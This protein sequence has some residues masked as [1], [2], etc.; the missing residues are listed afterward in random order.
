MSL[1][2]K[3][4]KINS[5]SD[6]NNA[7]L[8]IFNFQYENTPIYRKYVDI[9]KI[10]IEKIKHYKEIP[11]L[12]IQFFKSNQVL[13][14]N[15]FVE[16]TFKSSGTTKNN[17]SHHHIHNLELYTNSFTKTFEKFYGNID[18]WT[19]LALLPSY[20]EQGDSSL[21]Y[22]VNHLIKKS[23]INSSFIELDFNKLKKLSIELKEQKV[24]LIGVSYAL[25]EIAEQGNLNLNNWTIMETGGMKGRRKEIVREE[26][27][28]E[29]VNAF[30]V[31]FIHSEYGM[32]E[33]LTQAYSKGK[34]VFSTPNWMKILIR[35]FEDPFSY[36]MPLNSGGVNIIDLANIYSCSFIETQDI[37]K[38]ISEKEI[39]I[40]GRFDNSEIRGCNLIS[41]N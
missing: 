3:I 33:L 12:P 31:N 2:N 34:G 25:L 36:K 10:E 40:L 19:I 7:A 27:H 30:N 17:R 29:L 15:H 39:E 20:L 16:K 11:F 21:I 9:K 24:L 28:K 18:H 35:D 38:E 1:L 5:E 4:F 23:S 8:Q 32:T 6:F 22:M 41:F 14:K 37:G 13:A 26:L